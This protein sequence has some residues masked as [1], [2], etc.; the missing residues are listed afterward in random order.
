TEAFEDAQ[1]VYRVV[2]RVMFEERIKKSLLA[3]MVGPTYEQRAGSVYLDARTLAVL[4]YTSDAG[5][6][7][8]TELP[9]HASDVKDLDGVVA[10]DEVRPADLAFDEHHW[11]ARR[12]PGD[13]K[14]HVRRLF[15]ARPGAVDPVFVPLWK[16]ILRRDR[17]ESF[18]IVMVDAIAGRVAD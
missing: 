1:L 14:Q 12:E 6:R 11:R 2:Y 4:E 5:L 13:A 15:H 8:A 3:R 9:E 10:F 18:R 7:F 17:G 16:L